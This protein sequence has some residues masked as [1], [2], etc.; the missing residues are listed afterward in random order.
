LPV[1]KHQLIA[2]GAG[3]EEA[4]YEEAASTSSNGSLSPPLYAGSWI[5]WERRCRKGRSQR[6]EQY[7]EES[8]APGRKALI[9]D[10][11]II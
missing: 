5:F 9:S 6:Q 11:H 1:G 8:L 4:T 3:A 2:W 7:F 10:L